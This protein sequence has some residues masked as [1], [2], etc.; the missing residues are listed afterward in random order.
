[1]RD[2]AI[3]ISNVP[4]RG[5]LLVI[6]GDVTNIATEGIVSNDD[7]DGRM[8]TVIALSIKTAAG[9][10]ATWIMTPRAASKAGGWSHFQ[11]CRAHRGG[12]QL[13]DVVDGGD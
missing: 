7:V 1:M 12:D 11:T 9:L 2:P 8:Y 5:E 3:S 10:R 6:E 13:S 4:G